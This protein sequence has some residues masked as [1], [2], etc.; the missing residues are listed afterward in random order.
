MSAT[1]PHGRLVVTEVAEEFERRN[2][3][4][5][6]LHER[7]RQYLPSGETRSITYYPPFPVTIDR[8]LGAVIV[9]AD[10]HEYVDIL[11]NYTALVH[12]HAFEP[13][14]RAIRDKVTAGTAFPA[15]NA[16]QFELAKLLKDRFPAVERVRFTNSGTEAAMLALRLARH[17]TGRRRVVTFEGAYHGTSPDLADP[18]ADRA[19]LPYNDVERLDEVDDRIAAVFVEPFLGSG[20]VIP[21]NT[22][23]LERLQVQ[24][25]RVGALFVLDEVQSLRNHFHGVHGQLGL[26]PDL[27]LMGKIIGGGLPVGALGGSATIMELTGA[28]RPDRLSHSGTFNGNPLTMA[29][30]RQSMIHL[31][32]NAIERLNRRAVELKSRIEAAAAH[33]HLGATVTI[34]GSILQVHLPSGGN[35]EVSRQVLHLSLL[36]AGVYPAPRGML[37][38]STAVT[39]G[40][41]DQIVAGYSS[42]FERLSQMEVA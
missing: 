8:G 13:I 3:K 20:G 39:D 29:A 32:E 42:A 21:A 25:R 31:D 23:F 26:K 40:H 36:L 19:V 22:G 7:M 18:S 2:P 24:T 27:V 14:V 5:K 12:G 34:A 6:G 38:V 41:L 4:S 28:S 9:D 33:Y 30:G 1:V 15:P 17:A 35:A 10:G 11:N 37:N 16:E